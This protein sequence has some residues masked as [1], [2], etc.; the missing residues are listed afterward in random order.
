MIEDLLGGVEAVAQ[1]AW[2]VPALFVFCALDGVAPVVPSET[3]AITAGVF[4]VTGRPNLAAVVAAAAL[5]SFTGDCLSYALGRRFGPAMR[6]RGRPGAHRAT[7]SRRTERLLGRHGG[8][9][10][11]VARFIPGGRTAVSLTAGAVGYPPGRFAAWS[12][13]ASVGWAFYTPLVGYL[14]GHLTGRNPLHGMVAGIGL[15]LL[16]TLLIGAGR[17]R[18]WCRPPSRRRTGVVA[19]ARPWTPVP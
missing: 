9:A 16:V 1:S 10:V 8:L 12:A 15:A 19:V 17:R 3:L 18:A 7:P 11:V 13:L 6:A 5:G 4:A 14:G 2:L